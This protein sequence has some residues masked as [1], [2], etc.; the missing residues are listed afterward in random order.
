MATV[1]DICNMSLGLLGDR[2]MVSAIDPP[3]GSVQARHCA[4]FYPMALQQMLE[5]HNWGFATFR[6]ELQA[7]ANDDQPDGWSY[8]FAMPNSCVRIQRIL[9]PGATNDDA[10]EDYTVEALPNG[11]LYVLANIEEGAVVFTKFVTDTAKFRPLFVQALARLLASYVAGP[12]IK[13]KPG[14]QIGEGH[15][16]IWREIDL[17]AAQSGDSSQRKVGVHRDYVP[18]GIRARA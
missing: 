8:S 7:I 3:D 5:I 12:L 16:K 9:S 18:S 4:V 2:A 11:T 17:P 6:A 15:L 14:I 13:G 10:G 1:I